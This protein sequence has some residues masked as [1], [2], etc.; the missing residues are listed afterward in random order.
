MSD[1]RY[2]GLV[3]FIVFCA[4]LL[5][6]AWWGI[7]KD[8]K[9]KNE[10]A[11]TNWKR[12]HCQLSWSYRGVFQPRNCHMCKAPDG[13]KGMP[14]HTEAERFVKAMLGGLEHKS[15]LTDGVQVCE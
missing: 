3:G 7:S 13:W 2:N 4:A 6:L 10:H 5:L 14:E 11:W 9:D 12:E 15:S 1:G 8:Q